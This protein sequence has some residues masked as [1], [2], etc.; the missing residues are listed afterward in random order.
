VLRK[1]EAART[2]GS[3]Q[4]EVHLIASAVDA[5]CLVHCSYCKRIS[6]RVAEMMAS[7]HLSSC[8]LRATETARPKLH[9]ARTSQAVRVRAAEGG[10]SACMLMY[11]SIGAARD[12]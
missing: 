1:Q 7:L 9:R 8:T 6:E 3:K 2:K 11:G 12:R 4:I 10:C 5:L